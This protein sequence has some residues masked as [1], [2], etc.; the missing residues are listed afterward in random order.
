L[1]SSSSCQTQ[2]A[3]T[4]IDYGL[5]TAAGV[6]IEVFDATGRSLKT[7]LNQQQQS[8]GNYHIAFDGTLFT[9]GTYFCH[10]TINGETIVKKLVLNR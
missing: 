2:D 8:A 5:T 3:L 10:L 9:N 7:I 6:S 4:F 1:F